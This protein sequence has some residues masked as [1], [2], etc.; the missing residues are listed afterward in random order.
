MD[1]AGTP[2]ACGRLHLAAP[3]EAQVR[4]M[5]VDEHARGCR[6]G[7]LVSLTRWK[8]RPESVVSTKSCLMRVITLWPSTE[9]AVTTSLAMPKRYLE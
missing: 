8:L 9:S 6:Y 2:L 4:Y 1:A 5:A 3:G 7:S